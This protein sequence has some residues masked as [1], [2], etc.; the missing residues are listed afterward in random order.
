MKIKFILFAFRHETM[1][2]KAA[3]TAIDHNLSVERDQVK[4]II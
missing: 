1:I 2:V 3:I 4:C